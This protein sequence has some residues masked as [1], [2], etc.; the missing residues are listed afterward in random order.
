M[1]IYRATPPT[2]SILYVFACCLLSTWLAAQEDGAGVKFGMV[3]QA[4]LQMKYDEKDSSAEAINLYDYEN[5]VFEGYEGMAQ[6]MSTSIHCRIKILK[7][8]ALDRGTLIVSYID[9]GPDRQETIKN[10]EGYVYNLVDGKE[11]RTKLEKESIFTERLNEYYSQKKIVLPNVKEGSVIEYRYVR[12]AP[13]TVREEPRPWY[14]QGDIPFR[15]SEMNIT[16]PSSLYYKI[17]YGGYLPYDINTKEPVTVNFG[18]V[19]EKA[20]RYK[21]VVKNAPAFRNE[22]YT[23]ALDDYVSKA[24]FELTSIAYASGTRHFSE[25]WQHVYKLLMDREDFGERMKE[26]SYLKDEI[27]VLS[28]LTDSAAKINAAF[29]YIAK[30]MKWNGYYSKYMGS[31]RKAFDSKTGSSS[32]INMMLV[33]LLKELGFDANP[34][35]ISTRSNGLI[36]AQLPSLDKFNYLVAQVS[37]KGRNVLMDATE[38]LSKPGLPDPRCLNKSGLLLGKDS[39]SLIPVIPAEK[40]GSVTTVNAEID[41]TGRLAGT[42][43]SSYNGYHALALRKSYHNSNQADFNATVKNSA[44]DW[45]LSH[46]AI[47][48]ETKAAEP[49]KIRFDFESFDNIGKAGAIYINPMLSQRISQNPFKDAERIYPIDF[50][51]PQ[52]NI[53]VGSIRIPEGYV[54]EALP[55]NMSLVLP[56][57]SGKYTYI[58]DEVNGTIRIRSQ[59]SITRTDFTPLQYSFL[60][61]F[62]KAIVQ[63]NEE[64]IILKRK[65]P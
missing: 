49:F 22:P 63:K 53:Y 30:T 6:S 33:L 32:E 38:P 45:Q 27:N 40:W 1:Y 16:M 62:Y 9:D 47:E 4:D 20:M 54:A 48:N 58:I 50:V 10:I 35:L 7:R 3:S 56:E 5:I 39:C 36:N 52:D 24:S 51:Y 19:Q 64:L 15:W 25:T 11:V 18:S 65:T 60:R 37:L 14:F 43:S 42:Y 61:E 21:V 17:I 23:G 8:S 46:I 12:E 13:L 34:V 2:R 41:S 31:L 28:A 26:R 59:L 44:P 55:K 29:D 57:K